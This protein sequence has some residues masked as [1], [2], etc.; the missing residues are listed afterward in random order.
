MAELRLVDSSARDDLGAFVA[1]AVRLD[2]QAVVRLRNRPGIGEDAPPM[3][4]AWVSTPFDALVTRSVEGVLAPADTT[5]WANDLLTTLT[6]VRGDR[7]DPG[8]PQDLLWRS[9]LPPSEGWRRVDDVPA[10]TIAELA[11]RGVSVAREN[12]GPHGTPPASLLDQTVLTVSG[13]GLD[14]KIPLRCLFALSGM[15]F[16][17]GGE[18]EDQ[19]RVVATDSWLRLDARFGSVVR[20]RHAMLPLLI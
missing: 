3:L 19:V 18:A 9:A 8:L 16:V 4:D 7:L 5:V 1:R 11:D 15:G 6:V 17:G 14:V 20:R 12:P 13:A 2:Q 10:G